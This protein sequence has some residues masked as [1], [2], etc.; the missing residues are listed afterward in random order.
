MKFVV[1]VKST[2]EVLQIRKQTLNALPE[3]EVK[4]IVCSKSRFK[5]V[6]EEV[7][8]L[9]GERVVVCVELRGERV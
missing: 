6:L 8:S 1:I 5:G 9:V 7:K 4:A 3:V 2:K